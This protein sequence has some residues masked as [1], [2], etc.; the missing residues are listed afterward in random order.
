MFWFCAAV[1]GGQLQGDHGRVRSP[2]YPNLYPLNALCTWTVAPPTSSS[3]L[4]FHFRS[5]SLAPSHTLQVAQRL[6]A[7]AARVLAT[8]GGATPPPDLLYPA[9]NLTSVLTFSA[10][11]KG[12][13]NASHQVAQGFDLEYWVLSECCVHQRDQCLQRPPVPLVRGT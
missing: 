12:A 8:F 3:R 2:G 7:T 5:L 1:C 9:A 10:Q 13:A 11:P 6:N 4:L